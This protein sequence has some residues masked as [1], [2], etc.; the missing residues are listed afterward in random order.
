[1]YYPHS[2]GWPR[3]IRLYLGARE[4]K[5]DVSRINACTYVTTGNAF[6][7]PH[8]SF[9]TTSLR[10]TDLPYTSVQE[11]TRLCKLCHIRLVLIQTM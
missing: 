9:M 8:N 4:T 10:E 2:T 7:L 6:A 5:G 3:L 11:I 1:M